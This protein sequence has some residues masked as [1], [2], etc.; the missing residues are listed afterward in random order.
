[1]S[2]NM[3]L[4]RPGQKDSAGASDALFL[5]QFG[6]EVLTAFVRRNVFGSR[7]IVRTIQ[8][9]HSAQFP[10]TWRA[11]ASYHVPGTPLL[12]NKIAH[13][14]R[15]I[16]IDD[17]LTS[18]V[19]IYRLDEA[20]NHYD[21]RSIYSFE[22]G[23]ALARTYDRNVAR[24]G[25]LAARASSTVAGGNG[26]TIITEA[27]AKTDAQKLIYAIG[28]ASQALD[29]KDVPEEDRYIFLK[30]EQYN[31]LISSGD[32]AISVD[33]NPEGNGSVASGKIY[34]LFGMEIVKTNHLPVTDE[35]ADDSIP[36]AYRGNFSTTAGLVMHRS[37]VGT[38]KL[39]DLAVEME[40]L[41]QYQGTLIVAK[42]AVGHGILR[43][44]SAVE[45]R[46]AAPA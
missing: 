8:H 1:M 7:H 31:L 18:D 42:Y 2:M 22:V 13:N 14:E 43:P 5:K 40:Y 17:L 25:V 37:A 36:A 28:D 9:G 3:N 45:I 44:E 35:S 26:G 39:L 38:V 4:N 12:G 30:P 24:V 20:K 15:T 6:G 19:F 23:A 10:A 29:E 34:R 33:F 32:K 11:D 46:T 41:I 21:V 27:D 16:V